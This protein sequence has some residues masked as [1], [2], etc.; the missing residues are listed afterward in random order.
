MDIICNEK[1]KGIKNF[2]SLKKIQIVTKFMICE[3]WE[4]RMVQLLQGVKP[5]SY[6]WNL[7]KNAKVSK[8]VGDKMDSKF[9][10]TYRNHHYL[11]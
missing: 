8:G 5:Q 4:Q 10:P 1:E 11:E 6:A 3:N 7:N 9:Q 2:Y